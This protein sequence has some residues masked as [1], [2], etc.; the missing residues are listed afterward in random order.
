MTDSDNLESTVTFTILTCY[1][2]YNSDCQPMIH[3][4]LLVFYAYFP[5]SSSFRCV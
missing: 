4:S 3:G 5:F 2:I 1:C